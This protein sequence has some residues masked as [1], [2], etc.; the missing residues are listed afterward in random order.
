MP[1]KKIFQLKIF[2]LKKT[3]GW[4]IA[5]SFLF[6]SETVEFF[7]EKKDLWAKLEYIKVNANCVLA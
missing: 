5:T 4:F 7:R 1:Q 6:F 3:F 2:S